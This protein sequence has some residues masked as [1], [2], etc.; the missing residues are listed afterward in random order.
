MSEIIKIDGCEVT[1][2]LSGKFSVY[3]SMPYDN[4]IW[5]AFSFSGATMCLHSNEKYIIFAIESWNYIDSYSHRMIWLGKLIQTNIDIDN[6]LVYKTKY[7]GLLA[8]GRMFD[9]NFVSYIHDTTR[10]I[11]DTIHGRIS[12]IWRL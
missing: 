10:S 5:S 2:D 4:D 7:G 6:N 11:Q 3:V 8:K 12:D 1:I 9:D